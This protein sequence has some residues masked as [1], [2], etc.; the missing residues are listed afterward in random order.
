MGQTEMLNMG[1]TDNTLYFSDQNF[2]SLEDMMDEQEVPA[3]SYL[4]WEKDKADKLYYVKQGEV[5]ATK[6]TESGKE[7]LL[8]LF[9]E[10]DL[11][12]E[13][14]RFSGLTC[15]YN[16]VVTEDSVLGVINQPDLDILLWQ[17]KHMALEFY[18]WLTLMHRMTQ[19]KLRDLLFYGKPGALCSTLIRLVHS[20]GKSHPKG[21]FIS[22]KLTNTELGDFIGASRESVNRML[23]ELKKQGVLEQERGHIIIKDMNYLKNT[24]H[25]ENCPVEIC[26][27]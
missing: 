5:K 7:F 26:R 6:T 21:I 17:N 25:C 18:Q 4:F 13:L 1:R 23:N 12:G 19:T 8:Y 3:G 20:Y 2:S 11:F 10:G 22:K 27:M 24:C 14:S 16:A 9:N 15:S